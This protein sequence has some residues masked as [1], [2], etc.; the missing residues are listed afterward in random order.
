MIVR[1]HAR[2]DEELAGAIQYYHRVGGAD[3]AVRFLKTFDAAMT[4]IGADPES[5]PIFYETVRFG[6]VRRCPLGRP[7]PYDALFTVARN[8]VAVVSVWH[9][10]RDPKDRPV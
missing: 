10:R 5:L 4:R 3:L 2:A 9:H 8:A 7:W 6:P 1:T